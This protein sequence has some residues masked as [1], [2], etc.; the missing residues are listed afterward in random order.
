MLV[1]LEPPHSHPD[2]NHFTHCE[3]YEKLYW[4]DV[5]YHLR[6]K[7]FAALGFDHICTYYFSMDTRNWQIAQWIAA[8]E[9]Y[10][11]PPEGWFTL[12]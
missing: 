7:A 9:I 1:N 2:P 5:D 11:K 3:W 4:S 8:K 6:Y 12:Y 10:K